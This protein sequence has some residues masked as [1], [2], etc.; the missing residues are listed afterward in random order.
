MKAERI[1]CGAKSELTQCYSTI[2]FIV[3]YDRIALLSIFHT[4]YIPQSPSVVKLLEI[5]YE[6]LMGKAPAVGQT[7]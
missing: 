5:E 4:K 6:F 3:V 1:N 7:D 2:S